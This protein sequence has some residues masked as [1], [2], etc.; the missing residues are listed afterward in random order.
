MD[1]RA[2]SIAKTIANDIII[3]DPAPEVCYLHLQN[4]IDESFHY[5]SYFA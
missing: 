1:E 2:I 4:S 5:I 3:P